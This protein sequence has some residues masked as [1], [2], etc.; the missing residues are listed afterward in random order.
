[1][2]FASFYAFFGN[3]NSAG[4]CMGTNT[5][6]PRQTYVV[7]SVAQDWFSTASRYP[8]IPN[9]PSFSDSVA[10][11]SFWV[12]DYVSFNIDYDSQVSAQTSTWNRKVV[13][14]EI[15][16]VLF[17][18]LT[19]QSAV[20]SAVPKIMSCS[21]V[22]A[23][24]APQLHVRVSFLT[25]S[26]AVTSTTN[27]VYFNTAAAKTAAPASKIPAVITSTNTRPFNVLHPST[28]DDSSN[29]PSNEPTRPSVSQETAAS[30]VLPPDQPGIQPTVRT[31]DEGGGVAP[32]QTASPN[33]ASALV[34][35][36]PAQSS[37]TQ[38]ATAPSEAPSDKPPGNSIQQPT[39]N[40]GSDS[41]PIA[42]SDNSESQPARS[43]ANEAGALPAVS[44]QG[45]TPKMN[46]DTGI[47][48]TSEPVVVVIGG[49][50]ATALSPNIVPT[51]S[52]T[53]D[54]RGHAVVV[55]ENT[56]FA[57]IFGTTEASPSQTISNGQTLQDSAAAIA[58]SHTVP[59][60]SVSS[61]PISSGAY[62][63]A[64]QT[65]NPGG[66]AIEVSGTTY[67]L[68]ITGGVLVNGNTVLISTVVHQTPIPP[69]P[70]VIGEITATPVVSDQ[71]VVAD[72]TLSR[73]GSAIEVS[74]TTYSLPTSAN[75]AFV[76][77]QAATISTIQTS[78]QSPATVIIGGVTAKPESSGAY[79]L[80]A[81]QTLSPGGSALEISGVTY[82]L[83]TSGANIVIN[84]ATSV[85]TPTDI[86]KISA[87]VFGSATAVPLLAGGY[88]V[89]S[90][91]VSP[92]GSAIQISGTVY[93]LPASGSSVVVDGKTTAIEAIT[94]TNDALIT[95]GSQVYT[96][97]A[98]SV[99]P[100]VIASQTLVPGGSDITVS[101]AVFSLPS[102]ATGSIVINGQTT[103]F[104]TG[105]VGLSIG[106]QQLSSTRLSSGIVIASQTLYPGGPAI[107]VKSETLSISSDGTAVVIQSGTSTSTEGLGAYIWQGIAPSASNSNSDSD[108]T[109]STAV[110]SKTSGG[111]TSTQAAASKGTESASSAQTS[112]SDASGQQPASSYK[113]ATIALVVCLC[114]II[115]L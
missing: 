27:A 75:N 51:E 84:G 86:H 113:P 55:P 79:Y 69:A 39:T 110:L 59:V 46:T 76:N 36:P 38:D 85:I 92:G 29:K 3:V 101:G 94:A 37:A 50:S 58:T 89:G 106:S 57:Q 91:I 34:D 111:V 33:T 74:G 96:A 15:D 107:T 80:V 42:P 82:S 24:G 97:V 12:Y 8:F 63:I 6:D 45:N 11:T 78:P 47:T 67:S 73:G 109:S 65:L 31:T 28:V 40:Q 70:V 112:T 54:T 71:Y 19:K 72:Q 4:T 81:D 77:G 100:L 61:E 13:G 7:S 87:V 60:V 17:A 68:Q 103:A 114:A 108:L 44:S 98:A 56:Q 43:T 18:W 32:G 52:D 14:T 16:D 115:F 35:S 93:S 23:A 88:V 53:P 99:T 9:T 49:V 102:D 104:A 26:S 1:M 64:G 66:S 21:P 25:T 41:P 20:L 83:P 10:H 5:F 30:P 62:A 95:L 48:Q 105:S 2:E 90:Q 22:S